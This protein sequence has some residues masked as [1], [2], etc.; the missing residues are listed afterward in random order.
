MRYLVTNDPLSFMLEDHPHRRYYEAIIA[1][2]GFQRAARA[3]AREHGLRYKGSPTGADDSGAFYERAKTQQ[4][5]QTAAQA[6]PLQRT[7]DLGDS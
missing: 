1:A 4:E 2:H 3:F 5:T 7:F 6:V